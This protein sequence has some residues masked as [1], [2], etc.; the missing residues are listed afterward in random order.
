M[1]KAKTEAQIEKEFVDKLQ[2]FNIMAIKGNPRGLKGF[3][4]RIIFGKYIYFVEFKAKKDQA[5]KQT[6]M[7]KKWQEW[8]T[9]ANGR[10]ALVEGENEAQEL[11]F[12]ILEEKHPL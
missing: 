1:K 3:P 11:A 9:T 2:N 8:I 7:Q 4:D 12:K 10:Y 5:Y 6:K